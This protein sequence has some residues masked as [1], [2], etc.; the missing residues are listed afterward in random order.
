MNENQKSTITLK[1]GMI[2]HI[3]SLDFFR[4][5]KLIF[6]ALLLIIHFKLE[7]EHRRCYMPST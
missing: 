5:P 3:M 6:M 7:Y 4:H 1:S 2:T